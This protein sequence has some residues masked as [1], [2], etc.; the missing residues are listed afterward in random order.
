MRK[1][2]GPQ[3]SNLLSIVAA[4]KR[5]TRNDSLT[6]HLEQLRMLYFQMWVDA[7][8]YTQEISDR[9][10]RCSDDISRRRLIA[11]RMAATGE[12]TAARIARQVGICPRQVHNWLSVFAARGIE[13]YL[14]RKHGGGR[15][16]RLRGKILEE[17]R[18]GLQ[19]GRWKRAREIQEWLQQR[20]HVS[21]GLSGVYFW[22]GRLRDGRTIPR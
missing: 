18:T 21:L 7:S 5:L 12:F 15:S 1:N 13:R 3:K 20:H 14:E 22:L 4:R 19:E 11:L 2:S 10:R 8:D 6:L 17:F 9:L 16:A